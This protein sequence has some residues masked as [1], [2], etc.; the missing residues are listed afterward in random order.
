MSTADPSRPLKSKGRRI[1]KV[2]CSCKTRKLKYKDRYAT[3][4]F[5]EEAL[6]ELAVKFGETSDLHAYRCDVGNWHIGRRSKRS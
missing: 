2:F 3:R 5:A 1:S 6:A 4:E